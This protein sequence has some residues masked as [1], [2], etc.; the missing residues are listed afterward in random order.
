MLSE[1]RMN[2]K[3]DKQLAVVIQKID[4]MKESNNLEHGHM[5]TRLNKINGETS[6]NTRFRHICIGGFKSLIGV[7]T[8]CGGVFALIK[9]YL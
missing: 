2:K 3:E 1:D 4:D 8:V 7:G 6:K 9:K 5:I